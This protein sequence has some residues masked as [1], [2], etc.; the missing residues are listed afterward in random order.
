MVDRLFDHTDGEDQVTDL[1]IQFYG[2]TLKVPIGP[3]EVGEKFDTAYVD[4][5]GGVLALYNDGVEVYTASLE[6]QTL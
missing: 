6:L 4:F 2:V 1:G 5:D 3:H